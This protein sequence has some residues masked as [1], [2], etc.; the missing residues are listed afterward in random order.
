MLEL[1]RLRMSYDEWLA[2]PERPKAEWVDGEVVVHALPSPDHA[3]AQYEVERLLRDSLHGVRIYHE[4]GVQLPRNRVRIPD[5]MVVP[6]RPE[7]FIATETPI[8]VVEVLSPSTRTED[9]IRKSAEYAGAGIGQYW[10]VDQELRTVTVLRNVEGAW[11]E[12][13]RLDESLPRAAVEVGEHGSV[14]LRLATLL[15]E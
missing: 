3:D 13:V 5:V 14:D 6:T 10:L 4:V 9:T 12:L 2:L 8:L 15:G 1:Q 11:E 7:G